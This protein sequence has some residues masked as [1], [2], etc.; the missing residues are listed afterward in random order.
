MSELSNRIPDFPP[1]KKEPVKNAL[2]CMV[3]MFSKSDHPRMTDLGDKLKIISDAKYKGDFE[4]IWD[5]EKQK[6]FIKF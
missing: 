6:H 5:S 3:D 2:E 4:I 1:V